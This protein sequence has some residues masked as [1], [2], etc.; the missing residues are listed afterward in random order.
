[1]TGC[2]M[3][4]I[5]SEN[6]PARHRP[7][8]VT[9]TSYACPFPSICTETFDERISRTLIQSYGQRKHGCLIQFSGGQLDLLPMTCNELDEALNQ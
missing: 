9:V 6:P 1:M 5:K 2:S 8:I 4:T 7:E 3:I